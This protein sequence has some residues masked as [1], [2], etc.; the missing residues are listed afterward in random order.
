MSGITVK[1]IY[2]M[3]KIPTIARVIYTA[4]KPGFELKKNSE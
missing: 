2:E 3:G 1:A 4:R